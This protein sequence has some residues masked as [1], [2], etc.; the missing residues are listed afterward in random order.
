MLILDEKKLYTCIW[1]DKCKKI[2]IHDRF[3]II[4]KNNKNLFG[5]EGFIFIYN[6]MYL[7]I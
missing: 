3:C 1:S 2:T 7:L 5:E 6:K 4:I